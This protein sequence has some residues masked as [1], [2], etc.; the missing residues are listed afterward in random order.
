MK[1][2][3]LLAAAVAWGQVV[4]TATLPDGR[5]VA[6]VTG[7]M[8]MPVAS[9]DWAPREFA[10]KFALDPLTGQATPIS[11]AGAQAQPADPCAGPQMER[12]ADAVLVGGKWAA[13]KHGTPVSIRVLPDSGDCHVWVWSSAGA[14]DVG[15]SCRTEPT[16]AAKRPPLG[17]YYLGGIRV[18]S[19]AI[20]GVYPV[21]RPIEIFPVWSVMFWGGE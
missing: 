10:V 17:A 3:L 18:R 13:C 8:W 1:L 20:T 5:L 4:P 21:D 2:L 14:V 7:S 6:T 12:S 19:G 16:S 11:G 15:G 9:G